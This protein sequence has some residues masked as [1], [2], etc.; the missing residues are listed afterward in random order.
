[1]WYNV[2]YEVL[3][4]KLRK[5]GVMTIVDGEAGKTKISEKE[6]ESLFL[7]ELIDGIES[8]KDIYKYC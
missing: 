6:S 8:H 2:R 4:N 5:M 1:M 7:K 3:G